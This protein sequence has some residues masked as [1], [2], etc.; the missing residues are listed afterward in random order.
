MAAI[1]ELNDADL[2]LFQN[3]RAVYRSPAMAVVTDREILFGEAALRVSRIYPRQ[4]N[5]QY[6]S[7]LN[8]DPLPY[9]GPRA[10]NHADLVY[11]HLRQLADWIEEDIVLAVPA[12]LSAEQLGVLLGILQEAGIRVGGFVDSA[13]AA[14]AA[15]PLPA[16]PWH[17]DILLQ[18]GA[19]T[20]LVV[21]NSVARQGFEEIPDCGLV[22]LLDSWIDVIADRFIRETRFDPLHA[23]ATEQQLFNQVFDQVW[24]GTAA[25]EL[26]FELTQGDHTR[27]VE[28]S[29]QLLEDKGAQR[30]HAIVER[31]PAGAHLLLTAR[32]ANL[33]GL[34]RALKQAGLTFSVLPDG[35]VAAGCERH[36]AEIV[37]ADGELRLVT[38]LPADLVPNTRAPATTVADA[39]T[40][41][42]AP[43]TAPMTAP[44]TAPAGGIPAAAET[45]ANASAAPSDDELPTP[46]HALAGHRAV[47]LHQAAPLF[48]VARHGPLV[49]LRPAAGLTLNET[50]VFRD[51]VLEVGDRIARDGQTYLVIHV[52]T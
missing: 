12:L 26:A 50:P 17:L 27:R 43:A 20:E 37:P 25:A 42:P 13:V 23:A 35:A 34:S 32:S 31:V 41:A 14:A 9:P 45:P 16:A 22:R 11:L 8:G 1:L 49:L 5:Q 48:S 38:R 7:R 4:A 33:P 30:F 21:G 40:T 28:L 24:S 46:T 2:T 19:L 6:F 15:V 29:R 10:R 18:R 52:E 51:T 39:A 36:L 3:G 44:M 47:A